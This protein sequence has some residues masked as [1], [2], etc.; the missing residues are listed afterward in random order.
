M[1]QNIEIKS[2]FLQTLSTRGFIN[3]CTDL[4]GLD[5][6]C[7]GPNGSIAYVGYDATAQSLHV[8]HLVNITVSY[9]HLTLPTKRIV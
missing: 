4:K 5:E 2:E 7:L 8:G 9:T 3:D 1:A 6:Y